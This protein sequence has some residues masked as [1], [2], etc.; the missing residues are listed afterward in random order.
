MTLDPK[1]LDIL[2]ASGWQTTFL[3]IGCAV[4][5]VL[6][7]WRVIPTDALPLIIPAMWFGL[8]VCAF[9]AAASIGQATLKTFPV[10]TWVRQWHRK[11]KIQEGVAMYIPF[12]TPKD[13]QII[14]HREA[15]YGADARLDAHCGSSPPA[16]YI[17]HLIASSTTAPRFA[18]AW[19]T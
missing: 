8:I 14:G 10:H 2:K 3:A 1:W 13:P 6:A 18:L 17:R 19:R 12:M 9:L 16:H 11:G 5:L 15:G 4:F 7:R